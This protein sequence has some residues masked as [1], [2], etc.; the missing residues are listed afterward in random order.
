MPKVQILPLPVGLSTGRE[1]QGAIVNLIQSTYPWIALSRDFS[2]KS[3]YINI[4]FADFIILSNMAGKQR[5][6]LLSMIKGI[7]DICEKAIIINHFLSMTDHA[8]V[9]INI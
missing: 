8:I 4:F 6:F 2:L 3:K 1:R 5:K 9:T 7:N